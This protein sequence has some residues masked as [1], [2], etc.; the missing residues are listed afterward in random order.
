[1]PE[2]T[3][4]RF[5]GGFAIVWHEGETRHR[6]QLS[7]TDRQSAEAEARKLWEHRDEENWTVGM[8]VEAYLAFKAETGMASIQ[9]RRDAWKAAAPFWNDVDP[10][11]IDD[12]MVQKYVSRRSVAP[13]T[14][15]LELSLI[16]TALRNAPSGKVSA[17]P[18]IWLPPLPE[19]KIRHLSIDE[20]HQFLAGIRAPH[21][22]LY[23]M[24]G[25]FTLSRPAALLELEWKQVNLT[26]RL[27]T[28]NPEN[29]IQNAKRRPV[30]PIADMLYNE[31]L[32][33]HG[34]RTSEFVVERGGSQIKNIKKAFQAASQRSGIY[35]T[36]YTLRHTGAVWAAEQG[37]PMSELAQM[38]GHDDDRTTQK[39]YARYSPDYLR[40]VSGA[41]GRAFS[42]KG[43]E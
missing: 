8:A 32:I 28:L 42:A 43:S 36:P 25:V 7:S 12:K 29:R 11:M 37:V 22:R 34:M 16:G 31:L 4:Q 9:R 5:R 24:L 20:F 13:A 3:V 18:K 10:S 17:T 33:A 2:F 21:A 38:M 40:R 23:T 35:A 30:V 1:M 27:I 14:A 15:R 26:R 19:P 39:H 6:Q 41:I